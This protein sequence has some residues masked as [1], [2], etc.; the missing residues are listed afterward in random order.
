MFQLSRPVRKWQYDVI[1]NFACGNDGVSPVGIHLD[2]VTDTLYGTT[3]LGG[4]HGVGT[5]FKLVSSGGKWTETVLH[6]FGR[7]PDGAYPESRPIVDQ[8]TGLLYGTT[9]RGGNQD[10]GTVYSVTP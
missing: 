7:G 9:Y 8:Q 10:G 6:D 1:Y 4:A 3:S 5:L 2:N